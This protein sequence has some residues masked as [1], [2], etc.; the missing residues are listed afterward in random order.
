M[1]LDVC[2][3]V[4][5]NIKPMEVPVRLVLLDAG[6]ATMLSEKDRQN[7]SDVFTAIVIGEVRSS[8]VHFP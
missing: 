7:F 1:L 5:I 8:C 2:D 4:I 3:T 6:I